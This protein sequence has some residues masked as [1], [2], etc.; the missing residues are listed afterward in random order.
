MENRLQRAYST[1]LDSH[2]FNISFDFEELEY[3]KFVERLQDILTYS[4]V[5]YDDSM[6]ETARKIFKFNRD[7]FPFRGYNVYIR[8]YDGV[9]I[10][11]LKFNLTRDGY[12]VTFDFY[13]LNQYN[14]YSATLSD[15]SELRR[16]THYNVIQYILYDR[17]NEHLIID[18]MS[19]EVSIDYTNVKFR[20]TAIL[21]TNGEYVRPDPIE[22]ETK[23]MYSR[24]RRIG[25]DGKHNEDNALYSTQII[26]NVYDKANKNN[27]NFDLLRVEYKIGRIGLSRCIENNVLDEQML[28]NLLG[29]F[30]VLAFDKKETLTRHIR[31]REVLK[32]KERAK[33][34]DKFINKY[35]LIDIHRV[36]EEFINT[37][38][39]VSYT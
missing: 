19:V 32:P 28:F 22:E 29:R 2:K 34:I 14:A 30:R 15:L 36:R 10:L 11:E 18:H 24:V 27:L 21:K 16:N 5:M 6:L 20:N 1:G 31:Y 35:E 23:N 9:C 4:G 26:V 3:I 39:G 25:G 33:T 7:G 8:S 13:G 12:R 37:L 17:Q 38:A